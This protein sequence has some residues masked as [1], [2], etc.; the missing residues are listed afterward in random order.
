MEF[1]NFVGE[2]FDLNLTFSTAWFWD[3]ATK[4]FWVIMWFWFSHGLFIVLIA[5]C[6]WAW[7]KLFVFNNQK[8]WANKQQFVFL[9]VD[10]PKNSEQTPRA[11]ENIYNT[12]AG[13]HSPLEW[14]E[15]K[16]EGKFQLPFSLEI[17]SID[18]YV[19]F[20][21]M[22]PVGHRNLVEAAIYAQYSEAEI[23]EVEDYTKD[24]RVTWPND[25]YNIWGADL[26]LVNKHYYPI[27]TYKDFQDDFDKEFRDPLSAVLEV[28]NKI[29][30]GE[31]LWLQLIISPAN[32]DWMHEGRKAIAKIC[33]IKEKSVITLT[34]KILDFPI[35]AINFV[36]E[37]VL[38]FEGSEK[39]PDKDDKFDINKLTPGQKNEVEAIANKIDKINFNCK[40]RIV[41]FGKKEVFKKGLAVSGIIGTIKQFNSTGLNGFKPDKNKT[42]ARLAGSSYRLARLQNRMLR[43]YKERSTD[44][45][46]GTYILSVE[47]IATLYHFPNIS[48]KAPLVKKVEA[49][50]GYAPIGL[51]IVEKDLSAKPV[52]FE[53]VT[54]VQ[55]YDIDQDYFEKRFAVDK[56]GEVD[57]KRKEI[58]TKQLSKHGLDSF[59]PTEKEPE[60]PAIQ[61]DLSEEIGKKGES[62]SVGGKREDNTPDNLPFI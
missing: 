42:Q 38:G 5:V 55:D 60:T 49:R 26:T 35:G 27:R 40:Y 1:F 2:L 32:N 36:G 21:I 8:K 29:G 44:T 28:M 41:Y 46:G 6:I 45:C 20:V 48:V 30:P 58:I 39:K 17:V 7:W 31:Q 9:A 52:K 33:G 10:V 43:A 12:L 24:I 13:A 53:E 37:R 54:T 34:D 22:S 51:P 23:T 16:F 11:V 57:R 19:Q 56:S 50:R 47:E 4:P 3:L 61:V 14:G 18:G 15:M 25:E 62:K 59:E